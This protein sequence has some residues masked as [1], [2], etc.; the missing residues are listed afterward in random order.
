MLLTI[1][2]C[3]LHSVIIHETTPHKIN[4]RTNNDKLAFMCEHAVM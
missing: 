2:R 3:L 4:D 1:Q